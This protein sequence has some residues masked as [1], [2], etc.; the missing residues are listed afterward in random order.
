MCVWFP[1]SVYYLG[2]AL[3]EERGAVRACEMAQLARNPPEAHMPSASYQE[4]GKEAYR[5]DDDDD[6]DDDCDDCGDD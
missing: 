6:E 2:V 1:L 3:L 5:T 4:E